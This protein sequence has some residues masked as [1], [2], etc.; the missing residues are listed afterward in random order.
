[1]SL[2]NGMM[3][4]FN[5]A[6]AGNT[7]VSVIYQ[8]GV[9]RAPWNATV[10]KTQFDDGDEGEVHS[11][12]TTRDYSGAAAELV[13]GGIS[14]PPLDGDKVIEVIDGDTV[15]HE[16]SADLPYEYEDSAQTRLRVYMKEISRV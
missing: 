12:W 4:W 9:T 13:A 16:L 5:A 3:S 15:T 11:T 6:A 8:R 14:M 1:M 2:M 7:A 10:S